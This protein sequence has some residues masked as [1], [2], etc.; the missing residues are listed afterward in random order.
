MSVAWSKTHSPNVS[1]GFICP[2]TPVKIKSNRSSRVASA[3]GFMEEELSTMK[4]KRLL[5]SATLVE[6][7]AAKAG[8][9]S[10]PQSTRN[11]RRCFMSSLN[12]LKAIPLAQV[13]ILNIAIQLRHYTIDRLNKI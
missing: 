12:P 13:I 3:K 6:L 5:E 1:P 7:C 11:K 10:H 9:A 8:A 2:S 4:R